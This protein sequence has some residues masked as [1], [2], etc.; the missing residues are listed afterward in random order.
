M[1]SHDTKPL[2]TAIFTPIHR[3]NGKIVCTYLIDS[4]VLYVQSNSVDWQSF[5]LYL[6][7]LHPVLQCLLGNLAE[8]EVDVDFW[9][10]ALQSGIVVAASD[11]SV[12]DGKGMYAVIFKTG[13]KELQFQ[14]P[15]DC[16]PSLLQ[17]Y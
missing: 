12:K 10:V 17:S 14:G 3:L 11:S 5:C 7:S 16:H 4:F 13:K 1:E 9:I 2:D 15:V 6:E 8:Q